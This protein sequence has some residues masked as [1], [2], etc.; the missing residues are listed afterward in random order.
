MQHKHHLQRWSKRVLEKYFDKSKISS[1][2]AS[3]Q[4]PG[5][6]EYRYRNLPHVPT[7]FKIL[8]GM[9]L[10]PGQIQLAI[11]NKHFNEP[12]KLQ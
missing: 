12:C 3:P 9:L 2:S 1:N 10:R 5:I 7:N 11:Q 8:A 6:P 4:M